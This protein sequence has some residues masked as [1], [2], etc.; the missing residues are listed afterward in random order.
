[1]PHPP[2]TPRLGLLAAVAL[3]VT[4][5]LATA[6]T[7]GSAAAPGTSTDDL[8]AM[9]RGAAHAPT[10][11]RFSTIGGGGGESAELKRGA[12]QYAQARTAPGIVA[13][14]AYQTAFDSLK[15]LTP[16]GAAAE[17]TTVGY[18]S[19][20]LRYRDPAASNST[21][22]SGLVAGRVTGLAV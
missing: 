15:G 14:G 17:V 6:G 21:G 2:V 13:P 7:P 11:E 19:D 16:T 4:G 18:D 5:M 12:E 8:R 3:G 10:A 20:D 22:G 1:M 9:L